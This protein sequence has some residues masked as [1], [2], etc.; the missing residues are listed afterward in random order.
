[1]K[2]RKSVY[3][4]NMSYKRL[5]V[6]AALGLISFMLLLFSFYKLFMYQQRKE[7]GAKREASVRAAQ[8]ARSFSDKTQQ[9]LS[10]Y[11]T[12]LESESVN[13]L[14]EN[15]ISYSDYS[16][17]TKAYDTLSKN[18]QD[19]SGFALINYK[20]GWVLSNKGLFTV[21]E[22]SNTEELNRYFDPETPSLP[23][24]DWNHI[25][26]PDS[27]ASGSK[28]YHFSIDIQGLN[29]IMGL[30]L[31]S[32]SEYGMLI[33]N[34]SP[35]KYGDWITS[36][37]I[38]YE[39]LIILDSDSNPVYASDRRLL[40]ECIRMGKERIQ[41]S[42]TLHD[43][44]AEGGRSFVISSAGPPGFMNWTFYIVYDVNKAG[45]GEDDF[46]ELWYF[47]NILLLFSAFTVAAAIIYHPVGALV[48]DIADND[49]GKVKGNE[50]HFLSDKFRNL[51]KDKSALE[52]VVSRQQL[53]LEELFE[54]R[55]LRGEVTEAEW[56]D[57][58]EQFHRS[59]KKYFVSTVTV[60]DLFDDTEDQSSLN[61][62]ALC[63]KLLQ[64]LPEDVKALL[65]LPP[66]CHLGT[67]FCLLA[68]DTEEALQE[69]S[70]LFYESM[71]LFVESSCDIQIRAG[72]SSIH[73]NYSHVHNSYRESVNALLTQNITG[74]ADDEDRC[75]YYISDLALSKEGIS[76][77]YDL[78]YEKN[79]QRSIRS[80][81]WQESHQITDQFFEHLK[82]MQVSS[83]QLRVRIL[84]Y[85]NAIFM[86]A[87]QMNADIAQKCGNVSSI[88]HGVLEGMELSRI[89]GDIKLKL[90]DTI[91][92]ERTAYIND[93]SGSIAE[94]VY[95][96][97]ELHKGNLTLYECADILK[98]D[99]S[100]VWKALKLVSGKSFS[101]ITEDYKLEEAKRLLLQTDKKVSDIAME[102]NYSNTQNFIRFFSRCTGLTPG[103]FRRLH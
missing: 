73:T 71:R 82:G 18:R 24:Y 89:C 12:A 81:D 86:E 101:D 26:E 28:D 62:E 91:F 4:S 87:F 2:R 7:A 65:W 92:E 39:D 21:S 53:H 66:V 40:E 75:F 36:W 64:E 47:L 88:Y 22:I 90:L 96:L 45:P 59:P 42:D 55:L 98:V 70:R 33:V 49:G 100:Y 83:E 95:K 13:W 43:K 23:K 17:Y 69:R 74:S 94:S 34:I 67:I 8:I 54:L 19:V 25:S 35:Q 14:I 48:R 41:I 5:L 9:L 52:T 46:S 80:M 37:L 32:F 60:L 76:G 72:I 99:S 27:V 44:G 102:L 79:I 85:V 29:L 10:Y 84:N 78:S 16:H 58:M 6:L 3:L 63:L 103:K 77:K 61:E 1:M 68:E 50:I 20:T 51:K 15:D 93:K 38:E 56:N 30:P 97:V 11:I 31:S 57:Y